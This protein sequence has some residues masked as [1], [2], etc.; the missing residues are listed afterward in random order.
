MFDFT[1]FFNPLKYYELLYKGSD[2]IAT[3]YTQCTA[4]RIWDKRITNGR[5][6]PAGG[7]LNV[8]VN[9]HKATNVTT[10]NT[11]SPRVAYYL[12][13][14]NIPIFYCVFLT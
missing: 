8:K 11:C 6:T 10:Q 2:F 7:N 4:N 3:L 1:Y 13:L 5:Y 12:R 14:Q 9:L